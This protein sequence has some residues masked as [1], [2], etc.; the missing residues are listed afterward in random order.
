MEERDI[1]VLGLCEQIIAENIYETWGKTQTSKSRKHRGPPI[2]FSKNRPSTRH[3]IVKFTKHSGKERIMK[4]AREKK[5]HNIQDKTDQVCSRSIQRNVAGQ[6]GVVGYIQCAESEKYAA[7][8][9]LSSKTVIQ[10][11]RR[12]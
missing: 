10:T 12:D 4:A 11:R 1:G 3:I 7:K 8:N 2:R 5:V 9:S 6:K